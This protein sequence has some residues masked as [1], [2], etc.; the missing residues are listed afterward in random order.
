MIKIAVVGTGIIGMS[1]LRAIKESQ[2]CV[3]CALC[4]VNEAKVKK[5]A[6]EY[7]VP[8]FLDYHDIPGKV[9]VDAVI[10]NLP[11]FL[12]CES[13]V[14]FLEQ[15]IHVL[16]EKPMAN[17]VEECERMIEAAKVHGCK[18]AV[19]HV[20]RYFDVISYVKEAIADGRFGKLCMVT[21]FRSV[22]YFA[23]SRPRWFWDKKMA[24]GGIGMNY[25]A[26]AMDTLFYVTGEKEAEV[27]ASFANPINEY[28]IESHVQFM[29]K[30]PNGV[31]M[32]QTLSGYGNYGHEIVYYF[33][34][35]VLKTA[36]VEKLYRW[37]DGGWEQIELEKSAPAMNRQLKDFCNLVEG[38][39]AG[40]LC[41]AEDGR[42]VIKVLNDV[43]NS[44]P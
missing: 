23:E 2:D 41:S 26:H 32:T 39:D 14:F 40:I 9:E 36:G 22:D 44:T 43:Y 4:D 1:H 17:T 31:S 10:L 28:S 19:G 35:G 7:Q 29:V 38:K 13:T 33:T 20:M 30:M 42:A 21:N 6:E 37:K 27:C 18:L 15:G 34:N 12:H 5:L 16:V 3:L 25:G 11:H 24:G 8:Y